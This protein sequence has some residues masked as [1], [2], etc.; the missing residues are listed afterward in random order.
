[1]KFESQLELSEIYTLLSFSSYLQKSCVS[2]ANIL[3][4][5]SQ[6]PRKIQ[7]SLSSSLPLCGVSVYFPGQSGTESSLGQVLPILYPRHHALRAGRE[8]IECGLTLRLFSGNIW[9]YL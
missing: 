1:M 8:V 5:G 4:M 2:Q 9:F 7:V 3:G 6:K